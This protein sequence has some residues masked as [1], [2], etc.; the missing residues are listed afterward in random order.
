MDKCG[1]LVSVN[2]I[3]S[4]PWYVLASEAEVSKCLFGYLAASSSFI[5]TPC[6]LI[7]GIDKNLKV[8]WIIVH[9]GQ[10]VES[11][12]WSREF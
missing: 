6:S 12:L 5:L 4:F 1:S 7:G 2:S 3:S 10:G 8:K 9:L 11:F